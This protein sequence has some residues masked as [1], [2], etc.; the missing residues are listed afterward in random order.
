[1]RYLWTA[2]TSVAAPRAPLTT[3]GYRKLFA[4]IKQIDETN[5]QLFCWLQEGIGL[6][7]KRWW[8]AEGFINI[9]KSSKFSTFTS[10][11][12]QKYFLY[13]RIFSCCL[14]FQWCLN[15]Q[16]NSQYL[17]HYIVPCTVLSSKKICKWYKT[18]GLSSQ[19]FIYTGSPIIC[20]SS[21]K[22]C[23]PFPGG[24]SIMPLPRQGA[25]NSQ[26]KKQIKHNIFSSRLPEKYMKTHSRTVRLD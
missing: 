15:N 13:F 10:S 16:H 24:H 8:L 17:C 5:R 6:P 22:L 23:F 21:Q 19:M 4:G 18:Q 7:W 11:R 9:K 1:M 25:A 20:L 14:I 2:A 12:K 3:C 26:S